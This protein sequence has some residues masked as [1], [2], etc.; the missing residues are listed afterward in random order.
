MVTLSLYMQH[1]ALQSLHAPTTP[2]IPQQRPQVVFSSEVYHRPV[3]SLPPVVLMGGENN[4]SYA[5]GIGRNRSSFDHSSFHLAT[6]SSPIVEMPPSP[7]TNTLMYVEFPDDE[8]DDIKLINSHSIFEV[9]IDFHNFKILSLTFF[10]T[11]I[12]FGVFIWF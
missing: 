9:R 8:V 4:L 7:A 10:F 5:G 6:M 1:R 11:S 3:L 12:C 2:P